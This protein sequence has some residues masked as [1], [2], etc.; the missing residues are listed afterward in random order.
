VSLECAEGDVESTQRRGKTGSENKKP[1]QGRTGQD[2]GKESRGKSDGRCGT[3]MEEIEK[4]RKR[5][6]PGD[7]IS[8]WV[9]DETALIKGSTG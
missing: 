7:E 2:D 3:F 4:G 1:R 8:W 9:G 6:F 5:R